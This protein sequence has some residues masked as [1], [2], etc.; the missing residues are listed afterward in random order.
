MREE[1]IIALQD[2]D[3]E[4]HFHLRQMSAFDFEN[5]S[6][7]LAR[8][9]R[10]GGLDIPAG[11]EVRDA[12]KAVFDANFH[13]P[14]SALRGGGAD[15]AMDLVNE[16][17]RCCAYIDG[18]GRHIPL[19]PAVLEGLIDQ[20]PTLLG[21]RKEV[22]LLNLDWAMI[23]PEDA[24]ALA[25]LDLP[26]KARYQQACARIKP[27]GYLSVGVCDALALAGLATWDELKNVYSY[28]DALELD[29]LLEIDNYNA[30][31]SAENARAGRR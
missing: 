27:N 19:T 1:K 29:R 25:P 24:P 3:K 9:L 31:V 14:M 13:P 10:G 18:R 2:D 16:I 20:A 21:L 15:A 8:M 22:L 17:F 12:S 5:W 30:W 26:E 6:L 28:R 7:R 11:Q 4:L 23:K